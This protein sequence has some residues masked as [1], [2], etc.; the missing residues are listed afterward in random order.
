M[1]NTRTILIEAALVLGF[2]ATGIAAAGVAHANA[3]QS[4]SAQRSDV[5]I[6]SKVLI[7]RKET[8]ASGRETVKLFTPSE[9]KVVPGDQLVFVNEYKNTAN[10]P[11]TGFIVNNPIHSAVSFSSVSENWALVSV[12]G[13]KSFGK[14]AA[15]TVMDK[16]IAE[17]G[18][19]T[20]EKRPAQ[21]KDVTHIRWV[22]D[23][24]IAAGSSGEL[25]FRG[26]VK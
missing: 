5:Q 15:L 7:E 24:P 13:G 18:T 22:F 2:L 21:P 25:R 26:I 20:M 8:D 23:K 11:F 6:N 16:V 1:S 3:A 19:E 12:D 4:A 9:V 14:L 17:D 10:T